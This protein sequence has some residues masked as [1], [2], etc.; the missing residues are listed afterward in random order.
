MG[1]ISPGKKL[2]QRNL[3]VLTTDVYVCLFFLVNAIIN[4]YDYLIYI[5]LR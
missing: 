2:T 1:L 5:F 3:P 4:G